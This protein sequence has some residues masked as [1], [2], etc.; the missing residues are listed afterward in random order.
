MIE[1]KRTRKVDRFSFYD[2]W[3]YGQLQL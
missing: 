2:F 1:K 3:P